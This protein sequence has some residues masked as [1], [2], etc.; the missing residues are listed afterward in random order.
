[1]SDTYHVRQLNEDTYLIEEKTL[2]NQGLCYLLCGE[3]RALLIDTGLGYQGLKEAVLERTKLPVIVANTHAHV[4]HIGGNHCFGEIWFHEADEPV[5]SLHTDPVYTLDLLAGGMPGPMRA[6]MG[7]LTKKL[8]QVDTSGE[9]HYFGDEKVFHLGGR[10]VEVIPTPG[11]SP[12]SVC[13][14]DRKARMLFSGDTVCEWG[15][16]LH[17][18]KESCPPE[19]YLE[20]IERLKGLEEA[21]DTIWPGH[22]GYPVE[23]SY[24][25]EYLACARQIVDKTAEY[26]MMKGKRC[27]RYKRVLITVP[28]KE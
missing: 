7:V 26:E 3:E 12:G 17:F 9:Y 1:M 10:D 2:I 28:G 20:S 24:V 11:H 15:I 16:L 19:T 6:V 4:D 13:F 14:L 5:F 22:H 27:A 8:R 18:E 25:D 21:Y 23:K